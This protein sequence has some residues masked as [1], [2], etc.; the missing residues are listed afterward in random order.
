MEEGI[1]R[2]LVAKTTTVTELR[3][4][5]KSLNDQF[6]ANNPGCDVIPL[7]IVGLEFPAQAPEHAMILL[8]RVWLH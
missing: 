4:M 6:E 1:Q 2:L 7:A 5:V 8:A 3:A